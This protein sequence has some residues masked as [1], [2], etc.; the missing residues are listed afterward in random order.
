MNFITCALPITAGNK[1][2]RR[3][4]NTS[5]REWRDF[6]L[7]RRKIDQ[8]QSRELRSVHMHSELIFGATGVTSGRVKFLS[9]V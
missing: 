3:S 9:A 2:Q 8:R 7:E 4:S 1:T 6:M 5:N